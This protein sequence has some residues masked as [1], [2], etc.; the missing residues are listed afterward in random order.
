MYRG[1]E[2]GGEDVGEFMIEGHAVMPK[3]DR[4]RP[5]TLP[6]LIT[7][8]NVS[9]TFVY[10]VF[11]SVW[12]EDDS[13]KLMEQPGPGGLRFLQVQRPV[14]LPSCAL[15]PR[16]LNLPECKLT[17]TISLPRVDPRLIPQTV[18]INPMRLAQH[19]SSHQPNNYAALAQQQSFL[20]RATITRS[21]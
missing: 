2:A 18:N 13:G 10:E 7:P 4:A 11:F 5:T 20:T 14:I 12:G 8:I 1:T 16:V 17:I 6:G 21:N 9:H 15:I 3:D 19:A